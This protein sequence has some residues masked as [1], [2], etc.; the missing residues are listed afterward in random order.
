MADSIRELI[1]KNVKT[2]LEGI[3]L[4]AG[5]TNAVA[6]V[7]RFRQSGQ[8]QVAF[9]MIIIRE[10]AETSKDGPMGI[11]PKITH[12]LTIDLLLI[13]VHDEATDARQSDEVMNSF[14]ADVQK[15]MLVDRTRGGYAVETNLTGSEPLDV[16]DAQRDIE[17]VVSWEVQYRHSATDPCVA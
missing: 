13:V 4:A 7:Q 2:T 12:Q 11:S 5:Y 16:E 17:Q 8:S 6:S 15:A 1:I 3:T 10:G 14:L 9:P